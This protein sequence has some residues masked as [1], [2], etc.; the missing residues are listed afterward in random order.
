MALPTGRRLRVAQGSLV[1]GAA[2]TARASVTVR[3]VVNVFMGGV[4]W[5]E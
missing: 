1:E 2:V 3:R 5:S 4:E